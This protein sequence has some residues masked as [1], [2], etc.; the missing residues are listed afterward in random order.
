MGLGR[1]WGDA[2]TRCAF[3]IWVP[4]TLTWCQSSLGP[5]RL[6]RELSNSCWDPVFAIGSGSTYSPMER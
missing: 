3:L 2:C 4:S 6:P 5:P 1:G